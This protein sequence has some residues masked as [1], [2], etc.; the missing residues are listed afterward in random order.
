[1]PNQL[2][3]G[4]TGHEDFLVKIAFL[5]INPLLDCA[6][7]LWIYRKIE[8]WLNSIF[9]EEEEIK[10]YKIIQKF[11]FTSA[12]QRSSIIVQDLQTNQIKMYIKGS[13]TKI[14]ANL[15]TWSQKNILP[16]TKEHVDG[17]ARTGLR[18]LCYSMK[19]IDEDDY[20]E[21]EARYEDI[22]YRCINDK[23]LNSQLEATISEMEGNAMLLGVSALEDKLQDEVKSDLQHFIEAGINVWMITGDKMDTAESIGHSC[24]LFTEDTEV[25]KIKTT[26]NVDEVIERMKYICCYLLSGIHQS[27]YYSKS[28][29][30]FNSVIGETYQ[31]KNSDGCLIYMEQ[32]LHHPPTVNYEIIGPDKKFEVMGY[33][34]I[35]A[36]L[37]GLNTIRGWRDGKNILKINDGSLIV[38]NNFK[39]RISG[40]IMGKEILCLIFT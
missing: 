3:L 2:P 9:G 1:M 13:D 24:K 39:T 30:P 27:V 21:W 14:F 31:A 16:T 35:T 10:N 4:S 11:D 29:P 17:F 19:F 15:D 40:I 25:F 34:A 7:K 12:R 26:S 32:T 38:W 8:E 18:T 22:K 6:K 36:H 37:D 5:L 28:K 23:S 33:G 20:K